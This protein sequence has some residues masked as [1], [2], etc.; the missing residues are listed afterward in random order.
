MLLRNDEERLLQFC[1]EQAAGVQP[2]LWLNFPSAS[3]D[4]MATT[5]LFLSLQ[6]WYPARAQLAP[7]VTALLPG[8]AQAD[9]TQLAQRVDFD[10]SRFTHMLRRLL[11]H[12]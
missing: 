9:F 5:A 3:S 1:A 12:A 6:D 2:S 8:G 7:V 11:G 4:Q 10:C